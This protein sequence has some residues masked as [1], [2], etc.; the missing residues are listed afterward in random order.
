MCTPEGVLFDILNLFPYVQKASPPPSTPIGF[1]VR[2][3]SWHLTFCSVIA[4]IYL[5][6]SQHKK[7]PITGQPMT[8]KDIIRLNMAKNAEGKWHCPVTFKVRRL[9]ARADWAN[10]RSQM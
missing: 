8:A 7:S 5:S 1:C 2:A 3:A 9:S 10:R 6:F 4:F